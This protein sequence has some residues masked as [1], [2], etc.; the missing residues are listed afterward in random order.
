MATNN[1]A[2]SFLNVGDGITGIQFGGAGV[3]SYATS[4]ATLPNGNILAALSTN[5]GSNAPIGVALFDANGNLVLGKEAKNGN[6]AI[7][8]S[9]GKV[10]KAKSGKIMVGY[11]DIYSLQ[12]F[13]ENLRPYW[14]DKGNKTIETAFEEA[15]TEYA[16]LKSECNKFE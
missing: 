8:E 10:S 7:S 11:D 14:N 13:G 15:N 6:I 5:S 16:A 1:T 9:L 4:L 3:Y 2:P 12:Y